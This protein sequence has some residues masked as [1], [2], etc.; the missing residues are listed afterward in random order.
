MAAEH[1]G[2]VGDGSALGSYGI[3]L[4]HHGVYE[5]LHVPERP[6]QRVAPG[7]ALELPLDL[8]PVLPQQ[9]FAKGALPLV[10]PLDGAHDLVGGL[11]DPLEQLGGIR[12]DLGVVVE[13]VAV[14]QSIHDVAGPFFRADGADRVNQ[15]NPNPAAFS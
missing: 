6:A 5:I 14:L 4:P 1:P 12:A 11:G 7:H 2:I 10:A 13:D 8:F 15:A 3:E 9:G